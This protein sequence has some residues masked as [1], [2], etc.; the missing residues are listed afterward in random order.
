MR[1]LFSAKPK[2]KIKQKFNI[3]KKIDDKNTKSDSMETEE[4]HLNDM[5]K[6]GRNNNNIDKYCDIKDDQRKYDQRKN[7]KKENVKKKVEN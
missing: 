7:N 5:N 3:I 4:K 1:Q 2:I 6:S